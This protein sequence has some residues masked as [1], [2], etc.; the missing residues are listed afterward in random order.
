[1]TESVTTAAIPAEKVVEMCE[2]QIDRLKARH[3]AIGADLRQL[4]DLKPDQSDNVQI[5]YYRVL[6][7]PPHAADEYESWWAIW[8]GAQ[9]RL[10]ACDSQVARAE[11]ILALAHS[12]DRE[13]QLSVGDHHAL[14]EPV[15]E[16]ES[17][18][19]EVIQ[20]L[21]ASR[22]LRRARMQEMID[23]LAPIRSPSQGSKPPPQSAAHHQDGSVTLQ[24]APAALW[25]SALAGV[26]LAFVLY[27]AFIAQ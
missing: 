12:A 3:H 4:Y 21:D 9:N 1:M 11:R 13:V 15:G 10:A 22:D 16:W 25:F 5:E 20:H 7:I 24:P 8:N 18:V 6:G 27:I 23:Y 14:T 17:Q 19:A 26:I 2:A